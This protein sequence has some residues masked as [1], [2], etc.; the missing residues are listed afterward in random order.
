MHGAE[1]VVFNVTHAL[2]IQEDEWVD[3]EWLQAHERFAVAVPNTNVRTLVIVLI[4]V[5]AARPYEKRCIY[6]GPV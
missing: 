2:P 5:S 6:A 3:D 1:R 4:L